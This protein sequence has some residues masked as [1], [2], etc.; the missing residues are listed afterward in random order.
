MVDK[1]EGEK[2][3]TKKTARGHM[4]SQ[5]Q[6]EAVTWNECLLQKLATCVRVR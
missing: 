6:E 5:A 3:G 2:A 1:L 4:V